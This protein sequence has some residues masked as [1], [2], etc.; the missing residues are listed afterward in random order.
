MEGFFAL[1]SLTVSGAF[2]VM[3][4]VQEPANWGKANRNR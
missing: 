2:T 3:E 4:E 1:I